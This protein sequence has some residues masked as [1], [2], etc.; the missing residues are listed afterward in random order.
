MPASKKRSLQIDED[1]PFERRQW[2]V[3]RVGW[4]LMALVLLLALLG[5][6]GGGPLSHAR[7]VD[8]GL[9]LEYERFVHASAPTTLRITLTPQD[10]VAGVSLDQRY[11]KAMSVDQV[12]PQ[13][14]R[15]EVRADGRTF[16]FDAP[17]SQPVSV[18]IDLR[19]PDAG[20][21]AGILRSSG[22]ESTREI[23]FWQL[24]Y[25]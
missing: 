11:L 22:R 21:A 2:R 15:V 24:V 14:N 12:H 10:A 23:H 25:P 17:D 6:F 1:L 20:L 19:P 13:P 9:G 18:E 4:V 7:R 3:Q 8:G 5:L 16:Y